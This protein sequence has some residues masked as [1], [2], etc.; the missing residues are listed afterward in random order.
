MEKAGASESLRLTVRAFPRESPAGLLRRALGPW[1]CEEQGGR[2][3]VTLGAAPPPHWLL[4][5]E[6]V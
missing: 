2:A 1:N 5:G 4:L 6:G 3:P